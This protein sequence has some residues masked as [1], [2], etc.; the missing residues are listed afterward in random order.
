MKPK[1]R[2]KKIRLIQGGPKIAQFSPRGRPGRPDEVELT[3][4]EYE[5][6]RLADFKGLEQE[7]ACKYMAVSR[8]TFGRILKAARK[9]LADGLVNGKIIRFEGGPVRVG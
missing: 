6:L 5:A 9:K 1:G 4:D 8:Q 3:I 7:S 2:P